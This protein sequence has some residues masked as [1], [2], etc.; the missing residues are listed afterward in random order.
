M[1]ALEREVYGPAAPDPPAAQAA[2]DVLDAL[3]HSLVA[4]PTGNAVPAGRR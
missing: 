3:R 2:V 1:A 4:A